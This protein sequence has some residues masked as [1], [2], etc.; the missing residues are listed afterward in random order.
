MANVHF[1]G[2]TYPAQ[3]N[4]T[5]LDVLLRAKV[6]VPYSCKEGICQTCLMR[7]SDG[8][9]PSTAQKGVRDTLCA[10]GYF[11]AC[12]YWPDE[13]VHIGLADEQDLFGHA[14]V[15]AIEPL[16]ERIV[17]LRLETSTPIYYHA[18]QHINL[19]H[20]D[21]SLRSYSLASVPS[22]DHGLELHIQAMENG[23]VSGWV[24]GELQAGD[25]V[26]FQGP[27]GDCFYLPGREDQPLLMIATGTGLAPL[28]GIVR[29]ALHVGHRG[30]IHLYHGSGH[31]TGL[32]LQQELRRLSRDSGCF[33]YHPCVSG[34][35]CPADHRPQR[36]SDAALQDHPV[37][38]GWRVFLCGNADMVQ[39]T[40]KTAYLAGAAMGDILNDPFLYKELRAK[41][42]D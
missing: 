27:N 5:V 26:E 19:Q 6:E 4:D 29:D 10:Q 36:A 9:P 24:C 28:W 40:K 33:H 3:Q 32:Y 17:R 38:G 23:H 25:H 16:A 41:P 42:R 35:D 1:Q 14:Q 39:A 37:L 11:L 30:D 12:L 21:G 22:L 18:G 7:R 20:P 13:D 15:T 8:M 31:A 2:Q 34:P